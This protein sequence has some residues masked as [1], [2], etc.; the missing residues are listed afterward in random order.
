MR[1][2]EQLLVIPSRLS[3]PRRWPCCFTVSVE[4]QG[5]IL[6]WSVMVTVTESRLPAVTDD[7]SVPSDTVKVSSS[8]SPSCFVVIVPV[9]VVWPALTVIDESDPTSPGS[10]VSRVT[11]TGI[12]TAFDSA[13]DSLAVTVTDEPSVTGFGEAERETVGG[14][15]TV[16]FSET[17]SPVD[18]VM[19]GLSHL[20]VV[21]TLAASSAKGNGSVPTCNTA[22]DWRSEGIALSRFRARN[23]PRKNMLLIS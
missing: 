10:A 15:G 17:V 2:S 8:V 1:A 11:L 5:R 3:Q 22:L 18:Q 14:G 4:D 7:G 23:E 12:V 16:I 6:V 19:P 9:P 13:R 21:A 20:T